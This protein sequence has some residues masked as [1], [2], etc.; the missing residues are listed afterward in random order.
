V[1]TII[2]INEAWDLLE[3]PFFAPR[4]ESL[5]EMLR[6]K[7]VMVFLT[8]SQPA[9]SQ[10]T[11]TLAAIRACSATQIYLPDELP[12]TYQ[13][14]ELGLNDQDALLLLNM[15]RQKGDFLVKQNGESVALRVS[16]TEAEDI[17]AIFM[18]DIKALSSASGKYNTIPEDY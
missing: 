7:N 6:Q 13:S 10:D 17:S 15:D 8:T 18:N 5:L 16:L 11:A 3:N 9:G 2:V 14:Q 4:L 1:P 12:V